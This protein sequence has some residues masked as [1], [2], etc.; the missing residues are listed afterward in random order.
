MPY[1][2]EIIPL[3]GTKVRK[4]DASGKG[5]RPQDIVPLKS[6]AK[7]YIRKAGQEHEIHIRGPQTP[8]I[9]KYELVLTKLQPPWP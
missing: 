9:L 3:E 8:E 4:T 2:Q 1:L 7:N 6:L 5:L